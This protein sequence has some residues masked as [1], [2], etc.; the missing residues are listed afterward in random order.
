MLPII[1]AFTTIGF[2]TTFFSNRFGKLSTALDIRILELK[3]EQILVISQAV[4]S[5]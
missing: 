3:P 5:I 2:S 1:F 4:L